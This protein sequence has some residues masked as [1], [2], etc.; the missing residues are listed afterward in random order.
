MLRRNA[1]WITDIYLELRQNNVIVHCFCPES[2]TPSTVQ[3]GLADQFTALSFLSILMSILKSDYEVSFSSGRDKNVLEIISHQ[4]WRA[5]KKPE[6][7]RL[8]EIMVHTGRRFFDITFLRGEKRPNYS[9]GIE[10]PRS[11]DL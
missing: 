2:H 6:R 5:L 11:N 10:F 4:H 9:R 8:I 1:N 7:P 3:I